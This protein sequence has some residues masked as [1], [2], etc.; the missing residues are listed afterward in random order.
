MEANYEELTSFF[1]TLEEWP[2]DDKRPMVLIANTIKGWWP[3]AND[4]KVEGNAQ[5]VGFPSHPG[6]V[7]N[8]YF[9]S[10]AESFENR[11][12]VKFQGIHQGKPANEVERLTEFKTNI[13]V[14]LS[15]LDQNNGKLRTFISNRLINIADEFHQSRSSEGWKTAIDRFNPSVN[16]FEDERLKVENLP[17]EVQEVTMIHPS[18]GKD[19]KQTIRLFRKPGEKMGGRRAISEIGKWCNFVTYN[20]WI[21]VAADL[22]SSINVEAAHFTG[23]YDPVSNPHGTRLKAGIQ[24]ACNASTVAGIASQTVSNDP[25]RHVGYWGTSGTYGAFTPLMYT[26]LRIFSQQNQDSPFRL[27]VVTVVAGHSG[28]ET[29][30]DGRSHFGIFAPQVW[31]LFPRN[32]II[33]LYLWDYNDV[34]PAYFAAVQ[35]TLQHKTCGIIVVHVARP[36]NEVADRSTFADSDLRAAAKGC[37]L[38]KDYT[39]GKPKHGTV[40]VQGT[41]TTVNLLRTLPKLEEEGINIRVVSVISEELFRAQTVEYQQKI[42]PDSALYDTMVITSSTKRILPISG[43]GP[44]T[45]EY[46][47]SSDF[48]DRWR[49]GGSESDLIK[50]ARL[51][52]ESILH[53]VRRFAN[54][55]DRRLQRIRSALADL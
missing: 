28:P 11:F 15:V 33:N 32:Q 42:L 39:E 54:E 51:D 36:D 37:Y 29:A 41:C 47:L 35:F 22:S 24:E 44:L 4:G 40:L 34:A 16:P 7:S 2:E 3:G 9:L 25:S 13:D 26:P 18:S 6:P 45:E 49:T 23:H 50:E 48:D 12:N 52:P 5:L 21:T 53:G 8:Q 31:T 1:K 46:S 27:G 19:I 43:L 30:A 20:R 38:I 14:A 17:E 55:R 10:L